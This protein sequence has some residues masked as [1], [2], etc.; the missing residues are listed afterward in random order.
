MKH[1]DYGHARSK[2]E[3]M[4]DGTYKRWLKSYGLLDKK[5]VNKPISK[6]QKSKK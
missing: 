6:N 2:F 3:N 5:S 4:P 1:C